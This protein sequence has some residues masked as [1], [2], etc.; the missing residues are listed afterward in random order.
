MWFSILLAAIG[1]LIQ[2]LT[3]RQQSGK[4]LSESELKKLNH[5]L[6][7][8][9]EV[10]PLAVACGASPGGVEDTSFAAAPYGDF[11]D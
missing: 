7:K 9:R 5:A 2:W 1:W 11:Q 4:P 3:T 8:W 10:V 6:Y